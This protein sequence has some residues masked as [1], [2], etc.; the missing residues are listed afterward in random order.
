ME[1]IKDKQKIW[2]D[3]Y[4]RSK[5]LKNKRKYYKEIMR[6]EELLCQQKQ[7]KN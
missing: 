6:Y 7:T 3:K 1:T 5:C 4:N 2:I